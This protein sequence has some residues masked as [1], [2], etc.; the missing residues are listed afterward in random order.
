MNNLKSLL[1]CDCG[2]CKCGLTKKLTEI[3][4]ST[5][6]IQFLTSL[7]EC[8]DVVRNH[9]L[10][11]EPLPNANRTYVMLQNVES[12]Q[13]IHKN[14]EEVLEPSAMMVKT[15]NYGKG[16]TKGSL[17][18][19]DGER[20]EDRYCEHCKV[21]GHLKE[22]CFK[23]NGYPEWYVELMKNKKE[24]KFGKQVNMAKITTDQEKSK[25]NKQQE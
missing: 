1:H 12:H 5:K 8:F 10:K 20:K 2:G 13:I 22:T 21:Q 25:D 15:R 19:K 4:S 23:L 16:N 24:K 9:I 11:Q 7:N 18:K 3:D 17:K 6:T 14:F